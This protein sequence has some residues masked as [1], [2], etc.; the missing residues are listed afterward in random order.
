MKIEIEYNRKIEDVQSDFNNAFQYL[1]IEFLQI[2]YELYK[3]Q[4]V[5]ANKFVKPGFTMGDLNKNITDCF[6]E[7][8]NA[9]TV[10]ELE[11][12]FMNKLGLKVRVLRKSGNIWME[13]NMTG[14][15]TLS[16]QNEH[17]REISNS[18]AS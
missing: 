18:R 8:P 12:T 13:T 10:Y 1:R 4:G 11:K 9:L 6:I 2:N 16:Q 17:G 5:Q 15:W 3:Q 7:I 14:N